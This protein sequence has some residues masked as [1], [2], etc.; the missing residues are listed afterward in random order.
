MNSKGW[1]FQIEFLIVLVLASVI[2]Y[3]EY[4]REIPV[5]VGVVVDASKAN[6][7]NQY[8]VAEIDKL[9]SLQQLYQLNLEE[10]RSL[11]FCEAFDRLSSEVAIVGRVFYVGGEPFY[12]YVSLK[13]YM[14]ADYNVKLNFASK[15][16]ESYIRPL[17]PDILFLA[18]QF[19]ERYPDRTDRAL[20]I[21]ALIQNLG[22]DEN[23][24][25][26]VKH[27]T[28]TLM[29][30]GVCIDLVLACGA[31]LR[32]ADIRC[33]LLIFKYQHHAA[34][35]IADIDFDRIQMEIGERAVIQY[36]GVAYL[37]CETTSLRY[38][39]GEELKSTLGSIDA[40]TVTL[41]IPYEFP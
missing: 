40:E 41:V 8:L 30:G 25:I 39:A 14:E 15:V 23:D 21:L 22:Y 28:V 2:L 1:I 24:S 5:N 18:R 7:A 26:V 36:N 33:A 32:A 31:L 20:A 10:L 12:Y 34:I 13:E 38:S 11:P 27:P 4:T 9:A 16:N 3:T 6:E 29:R 19:V 37:I 17:T 35:G